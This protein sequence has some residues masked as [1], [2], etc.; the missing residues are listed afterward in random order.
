MVAPDQIQPST[1]IRD[2]DRLV[3]IV[4]AR[5]EDKKTLKEIAELF[6]ISGERVRQL[7]ASAGIRRD[8]T[9]YATRRRVA[10]IYQQRQQ[11]QVDPSG[12]QKAAVGMDPLA[13]RDYVPPPEVA[14]NDTRRTTFSYATLTR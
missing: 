11:R 7:L 2:R 3:A 14:P 8:S 12:H 13:M 4:K 1:A 10:D 6:N 9:G 5:V